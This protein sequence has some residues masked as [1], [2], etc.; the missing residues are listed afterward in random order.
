[1][2]KDSLSTPEETAPASTPT[3]T[4][5]EREPVQILVIGSSE[6]ITNIIHS[7]YAHHFAHISEWSPLMPAPIP[8]KL[9]RILLRNVPKQR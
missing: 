6:G 2:F 9:M 3:P 8:G 4:N 1:M 7:L 5:P